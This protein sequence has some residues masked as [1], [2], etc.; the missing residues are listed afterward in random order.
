MAAMA[1]R[2]LRRRGGHCCFD[3]H[4]FNLRYSSNSL[5]EY[6]KIEGAFSYHTIPVFGS[7]CLIGWQVARFWNIRYEKGEDPVQ[8]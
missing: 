3:D 6:V 8:A 5:V 1:I 2:N 7:L 4:I